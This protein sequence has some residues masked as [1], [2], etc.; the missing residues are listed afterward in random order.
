MNL[1]RLSIRQPIFILMIM[2]SLV[3]VGYLGYTHLA[4]D[5]LPN[6]SNPTVSV[7]TTYPGAGPLEV[8]EQIT[9]PIEQAIS[10]LS[11]VTNINST[12]RENISQITVQF[13][14]E[15]DPKDAFNNV[16]EKVSGVQRS[17]PSTAGIPTVSQFDLNSS[18]IL[19]FSIAD[20]S[21]KSTSS[22]LRGI[23][24]NQIQPR[25]NAWMVSPM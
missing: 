4:V 22:E 9:L 2:L 14:L 5:L 25:L 21:G 7:S 19:T 18:P 15:T 13:T 23:V 3:V 20:K 24:L 10:T 6:T 17:L 11:G 8:Q 12:S 1:A 16:R